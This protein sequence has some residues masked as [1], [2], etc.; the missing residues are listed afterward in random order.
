MGA[1]TPQDNS[2]EKNSIIELVD[3]ELRVSHRVIAEHTN[4]QEVSVRNLINKHIESF[5]EFGRLHFKNEVKNSAQKGGLQPITYL[6]NEP[7]ATFL[8]TLLKNSKVVVAFKVKLV[9]EFYEMRLHQ[10]LPK[11]D[12]P[13]PTLNSVDLFH[14]KE[15]LQVALDIADFFGLTGNQRLVS[16]D[17]LVKSYVGESLLDTMGINLTPEENRRNQHLLTPTQIANICSE[18]IGKK[19]TNQKINEVLQALG[20]QEKSGGFWFATKKGE[21]FSEVVDSY[22]KIEHSPIFHTQLKW[23][24]GIIEVIASHYNCPKQERLS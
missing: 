20:L 3:D 19:V 13:L 2:V 23:R 22:H 7:Q 15:K 21:E 12:H 24:S 10:N 6:L 17:R 1:N 16:A 9:K 14:L 18:R 8:M 4:N 5:E 11:V